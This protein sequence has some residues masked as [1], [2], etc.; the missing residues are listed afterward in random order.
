[1]TRTPIIRWHL[2]DYFQTGVDKQFYA[3]TTDAGLNLSG[4]NYRII[5]VRV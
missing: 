2:M 1:M 3:G 5:G 4:G